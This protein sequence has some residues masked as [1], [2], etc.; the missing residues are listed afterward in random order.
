MEQLLSFARFPRAF[1]DGKCS[2][3]LKRQSL[4]S[5]VAFHSKRAPLCFLKARKLLCVEQTPAQLNAE[6]FGVARSLGLVRNGP[7]K[8]LLLSLVRACELP[9]ELCMLVINFIA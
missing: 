3:P 4:F 6:L 9:D 1:L 5:F 7:C 2:D 8:E